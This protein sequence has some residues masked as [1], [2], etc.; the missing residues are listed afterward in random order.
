RLSY[1]LYLFHLPILWT[2]YAGVF[3][4]EP[5]LASG[6]GLAVMAGVVIALYGLAELSYRFLEAPLIR[7]A[8][9]YFSRGLGG[10]A[11]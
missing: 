8:H 2:I 4:M 1:F 10:G 3:G 9:G 11:K 5:N 6:W 7:R